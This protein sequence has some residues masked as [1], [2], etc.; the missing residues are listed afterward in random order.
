MHGPTMSVTLFLSATVGLIFVSSLSG[1][2]INSADGLVLHSGETAAFGCELH[3]FVADNSHSISPDKGKDSKWGV[4]CGSGS[5]PCDQGTTCK[6]ASVLSARDSVNS[7]D[8]SVAIRC[9][10][11]S[12]LTPARSVTLKSGETEIVQCDK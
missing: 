12:W 8:R 6:G 2:P 5:V 11:D 9:D 4:L 7:F 10:H 3:L 1:I